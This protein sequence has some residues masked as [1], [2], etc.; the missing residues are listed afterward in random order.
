MTIVFLFG[1]RGRL[2]L[3]QAMPRRFHAA[4][5]RACFRLPCLRG[6][7][8]PVATFAATPQKQRPR[9][10]PRTAGETELL[11][12][13][14]LRGQNNS[15]A[16]VVVVLRFRVLAG[17]PGRCFSRLCLERSPPETRTYQPARRCGLKQT[18]KRGAFVVPIGDRLCT[19]CSDK[20]HRKC[21]PTAPQMNRK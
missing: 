21:A 20:L 5:W 9:R 2:P 4:V 7:G 18:S 15:P 17:R 1:T 11:S 14:K 6:C 8:L 3:P 16:P 13:A 19:A 10:E 12:A